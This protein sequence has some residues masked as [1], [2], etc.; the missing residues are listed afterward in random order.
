MRLS[1]NVSPDL[2]LSSLSQCDSEGRA[3]GANTR[4]GWRFSPFGDRFV[5]YNHNLVDP[6]DTT[7]DRWS[8]RRLRFASNQLLVKAQYVVR[9]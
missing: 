3:F 8:A 7:L 2:Q 4:L 9:Y 5:V 1:A 6:D